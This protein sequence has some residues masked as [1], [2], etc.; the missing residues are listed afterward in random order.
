MKIVLGFYVC[1]GLVGGIGC[2][3]ECYYLIGVDYWLID[4]FICYWLGY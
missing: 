4:G 3:V 2:V 1:G